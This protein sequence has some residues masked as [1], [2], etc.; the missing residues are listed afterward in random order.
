MGFYVESNTS[1]QGC[2][3][4]KIAPDKHWDVVRGELEGGLKEEDV[5]TFVQKMSTDARV[6]FSLDDIKKVVPPQNVLFRFKGTR[7]G[8][9]FDIVAG[10]GDNKTQRNSKESVIN[11]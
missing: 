8:E 9:N 3:I 6:L 10:L 4:K 11:A 7:G 2:I 5:I 1:G